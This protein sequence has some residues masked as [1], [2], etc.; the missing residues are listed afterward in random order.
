MTANLT[1]PMNSTLKNAA[2]AN[3]DDDMPPPK[4]K[5]K[6]NSNRS[7]KDSNSSHILH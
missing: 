6:V 2:L 1:A 4:P 3:W 5:K 7:Y